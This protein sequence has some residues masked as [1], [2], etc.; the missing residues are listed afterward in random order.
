MPSSPKYNDVS[1]QSCTPE[2]LTSLPP[3]SA[4]R[5]LTLDEIIHPRT[6]EFLE[7]VASDPPAHPQGLFDG[8]LQGHIE[9]LADDVTSSPDKYNQQVLPLVH[10]LLQGHKA[11]SAITD[12]ERELLDRATLDF[13]SYV[14]PKRPSTAPPPPPARRRARD[15]E[16]SGTPIVGIDVPSEAEVPAFWWLK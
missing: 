3:I 6:F 4:P 13:A 5:F 11:L 14:P 10:D 16:E 12:K 7:P 1:S 8:L 9:I 2:S 15:S